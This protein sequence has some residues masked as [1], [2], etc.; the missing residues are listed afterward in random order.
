MKKILA[1]S[2]AFMYLAVSSGLVLQIHYCMGKAIGSTIQFAETDTHKCG[3]CGMQNAKN[4]CC[5]D[6]VKIIK[7][8]DLHKQVTADYQLQAPVILQQEFNFINPVLHFNTDAAG[9]SNHSP[10]DDDDA[11]QPSLFILNSVFRI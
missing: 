9:V 5:H 1:I 8:Q 7:L 4:K 11:G 2:L 10:P 3:N 6:E